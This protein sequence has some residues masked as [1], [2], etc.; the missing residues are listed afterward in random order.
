MTFDK[1]HVIKGVAMQGRDHSSYAGWYI[2][3]FEIFYQTEVNGQSSLN[4]LPVSVLFKT[5]FLTLAFIVLKK[6]S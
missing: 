1:K 5:L 4:K 2:T 3:S 6:K